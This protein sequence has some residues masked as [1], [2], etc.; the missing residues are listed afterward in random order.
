MFDQPQ[1]FD[2]D[3]LSGLCMQKEPMHRKLSSMKGMYHD[4]KAYEAMLQD[5]PTVYS[6]Y[7]MDVPKEAS[8]LAFGTSICHP[9]KVGDE[10][11]MT[12]GHYH[13]VLDTAEVY[14]CLQGHGMMMMETMQGEWSV[15]ELVPGRVVYVPG[16]WAHRSINVGSKPFITFFVFRGDAGHDYATIEK[17]SFRK[18]LVEKNGEPTVIDNP[19]WQAVT[20]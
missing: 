1:T 17:N 16:G 8:D 18:C 12:K 9:G 20:P 13:E 10:Y 4:P 11:F 6:F 19:R 7:D 14:H 5:D 2:F 3:W 15:K